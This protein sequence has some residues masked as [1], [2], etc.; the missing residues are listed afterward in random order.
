MIV[1]RRAGVCAVGRARSSTPWVGGWWL[2][3]CGTTRGRTVAPWA[4]TAL[5]SA[6]T[7]WI[8]PVTARHADAAA[9]PA[10]RGPPVR[11][12]AGTLA[13]VNLVAQLRM[14]AYS[15]APLRCFSARGRGPP[16]AP[17]LRPH[18]RGA[19]GAGDRRHAAGRVRRH[20]RRRCP[21]PGW[22]QAALIGR[23]E[24][25]LRRSVEVR[26]LLAESGW[27]ATAVSR[28]EHRADLV[29]AAPGV[30]PDAAPSMRWGARR[31]AGI[32]R[33]PTRRGGRRKA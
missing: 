5:A 17:G 10:G 15:A 30:R 18:A 27:R 9:A 21:P 22:A 32:Q 29:A 25:L 31:P 8:A 4:W 24:P 3:S 13:R 20:P 16:A 1:R 33:H 26:D 6:A 14:R 19:E 23:R 12:V 7:Q 11:V 28:A 2:R